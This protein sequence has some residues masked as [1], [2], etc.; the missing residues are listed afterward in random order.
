MYI[1][2]NKLLKKTTNEYDLS[3]SL[4]LEGTGITS[5]PDNLS[6]GGYL[7]LEDTKIT[8]LPDNLSVG[9]SLY[10]RG[11]GIR[12]KDIPK[13]VKVKGNIYTD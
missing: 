8:S 13:T 2:N 1:K 3:G 7:D 12:K 4:D 9:G 11:T 5:L 6:V 10:L